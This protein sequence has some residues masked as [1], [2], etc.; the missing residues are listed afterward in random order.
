MDD[1]IVKQGAKLFNDL[2]CAACHTPRHTTGQVTRPE[3]S[4][5]IIWPYSDFL[6]HD[7]GPGLADG[8][9]EFLADGNEWRT[10]PLWGLG[11]TKVV[12]PQAGFL[13]DGRAETIEHAILWHDGEARAAADGYRQLPKNERDALIRFLNSL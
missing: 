5:Q 7:M 10:P 2:T 1:P 9:P 4:N 3:L 12:N 13:H 11:L 6:L 8:R